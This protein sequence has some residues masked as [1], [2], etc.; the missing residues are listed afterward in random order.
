MPRNALRLQTLLLWAC[1]ALSLMPSPARASFMLPPTGYRAKD[2][3][4]I[5]HQGL[6]HLFYT[7]RNVNAAPDSTENDLGHAISSDLISWTQLAPVLPARP[8]KWDNL[9]IWAPHIIKADG[10]FYMYY[11]GVTYVPGQYQ[12]YQRIGLATSTDLENWNRMDEPVFS[13]DLAPWTYCDPLNASTSVR[14][15]FVMPDET[16]PGEYWMFYSTSLAGDSTS[17]IAGKAWNDDLTAPWYDIGPLDVTGQAVTGSALC[18]SAHL[19]EHDGL[20]FLM[21]TTNKQQP[22]VWATS[23]N[24]IGPLASWTYRGTLGS[25]LGLDTSPWFASEH[26]ADGLV[27]YFAAASLT[28]IEILRMDWTSPTT[29]LLKQPSSFHVRDMWWSR[30][31]VAAGDTAVLTIW[32]TGWFG[33]SADLEVLEV[34]GNGT[35]TVIPNFQVGV[36]TSIPL[37]ANQTLFT[38]IARDYPDPNDGAE[39][40]EIVVRVKDQTA[41][42]QA[43]HVTPVAMN[44]DPL[45]G[46]ALE[47]F[48]LAFLRHSPLGAAFRLDLPAP[49]PAR[50][51]LFDVAGRRMATLQDGPLEAGVHVIRLGAAARRWSPGVYFARLATPFGQRTVR[52]AIAP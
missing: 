25:M 4:L 30:P 45:P 16:A 7:R 51:D 34:D 9:H 36:P 13:C 44:G 10:I 38:W 3:A 11:T 41:A 23:A 43:I 27:D 6:Y 40:P 39:G 46:D 12:Y 24:P 22:L 42:A 15:A 32:A 8:G 1:T 14:D 29:F 17:M 26:L 18:E 37:T 49:G 21:W 33:R 47:G 20:W 19:F 5:K 48:R 35:E 52:F 2:F 50:L 28:A 31:T